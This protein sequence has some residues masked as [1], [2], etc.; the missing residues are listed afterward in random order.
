MSMDRKLKRGLAD[1]SKLFSSDGSI[2]PARPA[3]SA[4]TIQPPPDPF[5]DSRKPRLIN[6]TFLDSDETLGANDLIQVTNRLKPAFH[7]SFLLSV[8]PDQ[9]R[10][11]AFANVLP[12]PPWKN[13]KDNFAAR[14]H[15]VDEGL[16]FGCLSSAQFQDILVPKVA[17]NR[18]EDFAP[19]KKTLVVFDSIFP[20][21]P[22]DNDVTP[23]HNALELLDHCVFVVQSGLDQLVRTYELIRFCL[24]KSPALRCSILLVGRGSQVSWELVCE[25]F[26][27]I[28]SRF[29]RCDLGFLGWIEGSDAHLNP[30]LLLE[31]SGNG[32]QSSSKMRLS[33]TLYHPLLNE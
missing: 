9:S 20:S 23:G 21:V 3:E 17:S 28:A 10:Y 7:E 25:H 2:S 29:L 8:I 15:P 24:A 32:I 22:S 19:S 13:E 16:T 11:E 30:E 33:E 31:E 4:F 1:L 12:I 27:A 14:F 18:I 5:F 26:N 6:T